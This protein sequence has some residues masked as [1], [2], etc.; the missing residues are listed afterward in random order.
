MSL[1][2]GEL[3]TDVKHIELGM[4]QAAERGYAFVPIGISAAGLQELE[5]EVSQ[6]DLELGDHIRQPIYPGTKRQIT[7][8]H[9]RAYFPIGDIHVPVATFVTDALAAQTAALRNAYPE[10]AGWRTN[11]AGYQLYRDP[12]HHI[13]KHR[14]RRNDRLLAATITIRGAARIGIHEAVDD[15]DDYT[16]T[17]QLDDFLAPAGTIMFLR[18]PGLGSGEQVIHDVGPPQDG[19]RLILNLRM[20]PDI[21]P[22]PSETAFV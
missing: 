4:R 10:L 19:P 13:S 1:R 12:K 3:F 11:E 5:S 16:N 6:L 9:E 7:Q 8:L 14:D 18:A 17:R 20:R 2:P 15:P 22:G 21:L